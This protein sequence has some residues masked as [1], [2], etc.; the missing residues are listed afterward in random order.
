M[1]MLETQIELLN[2]ING[3]SGRY[4]TFLKEGL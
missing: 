4:F 2:F 3:L 1:D